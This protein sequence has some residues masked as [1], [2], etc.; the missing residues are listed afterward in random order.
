MNRLISVHVYQSMSNMKQA[1]ANVLTA[2]H[3]ALA[4]IGVEAAKANVSPGGGLYL[5]LNTGDVE[6]VRACLSGHGMASTVRGT[7][8]G[9]TV[10]RA[11][12]VPS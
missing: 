6:V 7:Q 11:A 12:A 5:W 9:L 2:L 4:G 1:K 10:L 8:G 3:M